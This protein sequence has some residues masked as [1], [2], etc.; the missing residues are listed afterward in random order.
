MKKLVSILLCLAMLLSLSCFAAAEAAEEKTAPEIVWDENNETILLE[1]DADYGEGAKE[2][3]LAVNHLN[4][5]TIC[6]VHTDEETVGAALAA[7]NIVA[8]ED[9]DFGLYVKTIDGYTADYNVDGSYWAFYINDEYAQTGVDSTP[10]EADA[11]YLFQVE[12][13]ELDDGATIPLEDG[14]YYGL[15]D[16]TFTLQVVDGEGNEI[17]VAV[18]TDESTVGAA[19]AE[20]S[21]VAGEDSDFGLYIKTVNN[22]TADYDTDGTYWA[23]Y[24]DGEYASTGVDSTEI[25]EDS[26]YMLKVE[27]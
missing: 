19:L 7:L 6:T 24:I 21:I 4:Q 2:F 12:G 25:N 11:T 20:W 22:I 8:G 27:G 5:I 18:S 1:M 10:V 23:F 9:S 16:K 17:A 3:T 26:V 14:Q 15:G 13:L